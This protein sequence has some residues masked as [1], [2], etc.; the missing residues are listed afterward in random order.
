MALKMSDMRSEPKVDEEFW[1]K[2]DGT[3]IAV[4]DMEPEHAKA[5]LRL[6]IRRVRTFNE[7]KNSSFMGAP[8]GVDLNLHHRLARDE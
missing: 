1:G 5:A 7:R 8:D 6:L 2:S 4:G 3:M